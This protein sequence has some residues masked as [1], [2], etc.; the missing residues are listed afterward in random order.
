MFNGFGEKDLKIRFEV[1]TAATV[2]NV[3]FLDKNNKFVP[4]RRPITS[5]LQI[6]AGYAI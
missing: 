1:L 3:V 5:P 2:K 4:H 6:R